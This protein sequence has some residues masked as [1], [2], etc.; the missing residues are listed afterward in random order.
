MRWPTQPAPSCWL[1]L[2]CLAGCDSLWAT[3]VASTPD[4]C[5]ANSGICK[6]SQQCNTTTQF[7]EDRSKG[8]ARCSVDRWCWENPL[9][10]GHPLRAVWGTSADHLWA[11]GDQGTAWLWDGRAWTP[12]DVNGTKQDLY[13]VWGT[14]PSDIWTVGLGGVIFHYDGQSWKGAPSPANGNALTSI[15]CAGPQRCFAVGQNG[16]IVE[17]DGVQWTLVTPA[18]ASKYLFGVWGRGSSDVYAVGDFG[19]VLHRDAQKWSPAAG[20]NATTTLYSVHGLDEPD[21]D[22]WIAGLNNIWYKPKGGASFGSQSVSGNQRRVFA[23]SKGVWAAGDGPLLRW[24]GSTWVPELLKLPPVV[25]YGIFGLP[26]ADPTLWAV[27]Q[28]GQILRRDQGQ[29]T[30]SAPASVGPKVYLSDVWPQS[31]TDVWAAGSYGTILHRDGNGWAPKRQGQKEEGYSKI[32]SAGPSSPV[33]FLGP[34]TGRMLKWRDGQ[35]EPAIMVAAATLNAIGGTADNN[36]WVVGASNTVLRFDGQQ[37]SPFMPA[38]DAPGG[39]GAW[40]G[41]YASGRHVWLIGGGGHIRH[42]DGSQWIAENQMGVD[43]MSISGYGDD[44]WAGAT[45]RLLHRDPTQG[46][47]S[48]AMAL[49]GNGYSLRLL[50]P[51]QGWMLS[52]GGVYRFDGVTWIPEERGAG[53]LLWGI[54][55]LP[56]GPTWA[57]GDVGTILAKY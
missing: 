45:Y 56:D 47:W 11:V 35:F 14:S 48:E 23:T 26:G 30:E 52:T 16:T 32:W 5:V 1:L 40:N 28:G 51:R 33:W 57:V 50:G 7:C 54:G 12:Q 19:T 9:P 36:I 38:P 22:L 29:F 34:S 39:T 15:W 42:F 8:G 24:D 43:L 53:A 37:W 31:A 55:G 46:K 25:M 4:N 17:Y 18:P 49:P 10:H 44:I 41:V 27:G 3:Y 2:L 13:G 20:I 6:A 21:G